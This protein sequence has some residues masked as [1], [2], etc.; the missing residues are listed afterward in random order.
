SITAQ[1]V[2]GPTNGTVTLN[3][4]GTFSYTPN[5]SY[6]GSDSFTFTWSDGVSLSDTATVSLDVYDGPLAAFDD[7][8]SDIHFEAREDGWLILRSAG[9][10]ANDQRA[11][12]S[13]VG[14]V[15]QPGCGEVVVD[16]N[17]TFC[18][19]PTR[20]YDARPEVDS[21]TYQVT[22]G[23][24]TA[25]ASVHVTLTNLYP[26]DPKVAGKGK[27]LVG[28]PP[29]ADLG[30]RKFDDGLRRYPI[31]PGS[32]VFVSD[33]TVMLD[34]WAIW[35]QTPWFGRVQ[36]HQG[37]GSWQQLVQIVSANYAD[38]SLPAIYISGHGSY[39]GVQTQAGAGSDPKSANSPFRGDLIVETLS[40]EQA[41]A[42]RRKLQ[43]DGVIVLFGCHQAS[44]EENTALLRIAG[45]NYQAVPL[46]RKT[47]MLADKI[48]KPVIANTGTTCDGNYGYG[49]WYQFD[50]RPQ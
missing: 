50:P 20:P 26:T 14:V 39:G 5:A 47:Q 44:G 22:N 30:A 16:S 17:G 41:A 11:N 4:D 13:V 24:A 19:L 3:P 43:E 15:E 42:L 46:A 10:L 8:Y 49:I 1:L 12:L 38:G 36:I 6:V 21:F 33:R 7:F 29:P 28:Q 23:V 18:Y 40:D 31:L 48:G 32:A 45:N 2:T 37:I 34:G 27:D 35:W 9:V 25:R